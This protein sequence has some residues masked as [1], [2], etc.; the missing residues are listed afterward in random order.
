MASNVADASRSPSEPGTAATLT[1][2]PVTARLLLVL[3]IATGVVA[4]ILADASEESSLALSKAG[5]D[6]TR[7]LRAMAV[8]EAGMAAAVTAAVMWRPGTGLG[9]AWLAA[10]AVACAAM[11]TGPARIWGMAHV[12]TGALLSQAGLLTANV[13]LWR[14]PEVAWLA[15]MVAAR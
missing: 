3:A 7:L 2:S 11:A 12:G 15:A 13:L 9:P 4:G 5:G 10:Y 1:G 6:L 14:D 8:L